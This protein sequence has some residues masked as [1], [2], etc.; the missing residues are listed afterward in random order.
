MTTFKRF[1]IDLLFLT[2]A[3]L[4]FTLAHPNPVFTR[5]AGGLAYFILLPVSWVLS[6]SSLRLN[7]FYGAYFG[8]LSYALFN[9]WLA[10]FDPLAWIIVPLFFML[11]HMI[12][13]P[14]L[15]LVLRWK[16]GWSVWLAAFV[17]VAYEYLRHYGYLGYSYG[18]LGYTQYEFLP[19][20]QSAEWA[21]VWIV[22]FL[23]V[24]PAFWLNR[25]FLDSQ[26]HRTLV[27]GLVLGSLAAVNIGWGIISQRDF[28]EN[29]RWRVALIQHDVDPWRGGLPMYR[30]GF[31]RLKRLSNAAL[32][33]KPQAVI[34]S[35]TAFVPSIE[36]HRRYRPDPL[37]WELVSEFLD[38]SS[39]FPVPLVLGNG[40]GERVPGPDGPV[41][42][43]SNAV[44][45]FHR[46][47]LRGIYKKVHLVPF[48]EHFP[49]GDVFPW[50]E[51][52]LLANDVHF[53]KPGSEWTNLDI[54]G[55]RVGTPVCFEDTFGYI[56][57]EFVSRGAVALI[58]L[59]ND[60]WARSL[61][62]M[63]QHYSMAVFR[64]IENRRSLVRATNGGWTAAFDPNGRVI[65][66]LPP[67]ME[68]YLIADVPIPIDK[69]LTFYTQHG[70]WFAVLCLVI[71]LGG[72]SILVVLR[73][74]KGSCWFT[75]NEK[76]SPA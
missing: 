20:I 39:R 52:F 28:T 73:L 33:E 36:Y 38:F 10:V 49:Y 35:E 3:A 60:S 23:T 48:T 69:S 76:D 62:N 2:L 74:T 7:L 51:K 53:W 29:T 25:L 59:T 11:Y 70:D 13:F 6:R 72:V 67:L 45:L 40:H 31:E 58:N 66:E 27:Q 46:G 8:W 37:T 30:E 12:L 43:D 24:V 56:S 50:F 21:G 44:L 64:A 5:G 57:R 65:A 47:E 18:I 42:E 19:W 55:V 54:E 41:R 61:A 4:L 14:I 75:I 16:S 71:S 32:N 22:S 63:R 68:G 26:A 34:W 15:S 1:W 17:W 9:H